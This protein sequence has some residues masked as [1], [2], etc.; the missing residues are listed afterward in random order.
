MA[1]LFSSFFTRCA[2][3]ALTALLLSSQAG[4]QPAWPSKPVRLV[5]PYAAGGT[6]DYAGRQVAQKLTE[7]LGQSFFVENKAGGSGT[8]G[9]QMVVRSAADG[10]TFLVNDTTYGMLPSLFAKLPWDHAND[11]IPVTTLSVTPVV[12]VVAANSPFKT[13]KELMDFARESRQAQFRLGRQR[14][15]HA[16]VRRG[17]QEGRT[18]FHHPH[19]LQ[20]CR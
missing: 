13:A 2:A 18:P 12:L 7:L 5:V 3:G 4:A 10:A 8:I 1:R 6:T 9:T 14:Q 16:P 19:P 15:F 20:G 11:L 17:V